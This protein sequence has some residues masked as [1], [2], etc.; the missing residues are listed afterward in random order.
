LL[1][2]LLTRV[3]SWTQI[4]GSFEDAYITFRFAAHWAQGLG[5][6]Y[7]EGEK[8]WGYSSV[9]WTGVLALSSK[10]GLSIPAAA[11]VLGVAADVASLVFGMRLLARHSAAAAYG[12][13]FFFAIHPYVAAM[14]V[15]GMEVS[16]FWCL[17]VVT[18]SSLTGN[19]WVAGLL[20]GALA[21]VRP[22][23]TVS[24]AVMALWAPWRS[25][26][27][28]LGLFAVP[29]VALSAYYGQ[30]LPQSVLAKAST[31]GAHGPLGGRHWYDWFVPMHFGA[32]PETAEGDNLLP[33][34][35]LFLPGMVGALP[36]LW[37]EPRSGAAAL[38]AGGGCVLL[39]YTAFGV[40]YFNWYLLVPLLTVVTA[41]S[42]GLGSMRLPLTIWLAGLLFVV[43]NWTLLPKLYRGRAQVEQQLFKGAGD[44][45]RQDAES[46]GLMRQRRPLVLL[47]PIGWVG[48]QTGF[49]V[50]DEI[51]LVSPEVAR[52]RQ[53]GAG[54]FTDLVEGERPDY[55]VVRGSLL[56]SGQAWA[57]GGAPFR[58][59]EERERVLANYERIFP[60][61]G[62]PVGAND[63]IAMR[64]VER[65]P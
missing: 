57:G 40:A 62:V 51:G 45:M 18:A 27:L 63:V 16:L 5:P 3:Y 49:R 25:R 46:R 47:E 31:Y 35:V 17:L 44:A 42:L 13:G 4:P 29:W 20:L 36:V 41:A 21:L 65:T 33:L 43:G 28:A 30:W 7:N 64:R 52:R 56:T 34:A 24:A 14:A 54:W 50:M 48:W 55:V 32:W 2:L 60:P 53:R 37:R 26:L 9:L 10:L 61:A 58:Q 38:V 11:R 6:V 15:S 8:V 22:E 12:Y 19:P 59:L 1:V 39:G 23:G